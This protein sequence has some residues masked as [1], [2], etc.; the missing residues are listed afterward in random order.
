MDGLTDGRTDAPDSSDVD[1]LFVS[2]V[3]SEHK[4]RHLLHVDLSCLPIKE[5][6]LEAETD[7]RTTNNNTNNN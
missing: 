4:L 7:H 2:L 1:F 6:A 3:I 5:D